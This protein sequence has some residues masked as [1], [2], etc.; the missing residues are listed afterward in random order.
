MLEDVVKVDPMTPKPDSLN[1]TR[2]PGG[3]RTRRKKREPAPETA[4]PAEPTP[5][6]DGENPPHLLDIRV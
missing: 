3:G 1:Q 2:S 4:T 5:Q 6:D